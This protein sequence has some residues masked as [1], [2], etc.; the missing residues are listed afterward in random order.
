MTRTA[1]YNAIDSERNYQD[2]Q[3]QIDSSHV[4]EDF[5]LAA[6]LEAIR[7]NLDLANK[8]WY[9]ERA[10]YPDAMEYIRKIAAICVQ[11]GEKYNMPRR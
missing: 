4:V 1:V 5:P 7:Y 6:G 2:Q 9:T 3:K 8:R 10:P 11:M